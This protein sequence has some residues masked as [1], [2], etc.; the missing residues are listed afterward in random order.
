M[1][2][3]FA[4]EETLAKISENPERFPLTHRSA[5]GGLIRRYPYFCRV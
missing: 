2:L 4:V 3:N 5:N 1:I